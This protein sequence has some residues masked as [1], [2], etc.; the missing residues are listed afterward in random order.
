MQV[1]SVTLLTMGQEINF[2]KEVKSVADTY[3]IA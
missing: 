2:S 3:E 1:S